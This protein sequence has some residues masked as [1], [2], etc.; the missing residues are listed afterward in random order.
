[1]IDFIRMGLIELWGSR[2]EPNLQNEKFLPTV[3]FE[4]GLFLLR[5]EHATCTTAVRG[6]ISVSGLKFTGFYFSVIFLEIRNVLHGKD[7]AYSYAVN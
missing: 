5:S 6:L 1:M 3:G 2:V 7:V 4:P